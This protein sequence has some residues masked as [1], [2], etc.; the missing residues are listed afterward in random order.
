M[1]LVFAKDTRH[2]HDADGAGITIHKGSHWPASDPIVRAHPDVFSTDPRWGLF[3]TREP[4]GFRDE[5]EQPP[6]EQATRA[7]GEQRTN[8][9]R[10]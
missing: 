8:K 6:V 1:D 10:H 3:F 7:P 4:A 5:D 9:R 2:V